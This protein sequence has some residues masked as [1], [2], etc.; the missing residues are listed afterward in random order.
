MDGEALHGPVGFFQAGAAAV[1]EHV[2]YQ[3]LMSWWS[4]VGTVQAL[5]KKQG[6]GDIKRK[7]F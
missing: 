4:L 6:W 1:I 5:R 7:A 2:G 3:Q